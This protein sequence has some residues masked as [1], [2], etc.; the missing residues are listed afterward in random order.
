MHYVV[1]GRDGWA[2]LRLAKTVLMAALALA[3][4]LTRM[5]PM[6]ADANAGDDAKANDDKFLMLA[7][8]LVT[9]N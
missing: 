2:S 8:L 9:S 6:P 7:V 3:L 4:A 1:I 5:T